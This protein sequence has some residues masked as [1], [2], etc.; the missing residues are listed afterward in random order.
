VRLPQA[1]HTG[2]PR[3]LLLAG[4]LSTTVLAVA[5]VGAGAIPR[6]RDAIASTL[7][8]NVLHDND[9]LQTICTVAMLIA[10]VVLVSCWWRLR[11]LLNGLT[12][13]ALL[14][15]AGVWSLPLLFAPPLF[16][17][18]V[19]AY[20]GQ[21]EL[22]A[23]HI[24]PY[25]YGPAALTGKWVLRVDDPWRSSPAP[26]GPVW[27]WLAGRVVLI[28]GEHV[29]LAVIA[30]RFVAVAGL[31]LVAATLPILARQHGVAPQRA[32]WLGLAN[33]FVLLHGVAG[34]HNDVLMVGLLVAG[35][36]VAGRSPT[37]LRLVLAAVLIT[38]AAL[39][40]LPAI[41]ALGF[42]PMLYPGWVARLRSAAVVL[43]TS[44]VTALGLTAATG[45]GWGWVHTL[46]AGATKLSIFSPVTGIGVAVGNAL[47]ALGLVS[48]PNAVIR[49]AAEGGLALAVLVGVGLLFRAHTV[50]P[51]RALALTMV[52]VVALGPIVQPWYLLWGLVLMAAVGG[53]RAMLP[54]GALSIALCLALLPNGRS[55]IRPPLYGT[56]VVVAAGFATY[57]VRRSGRQLTELPGRPVN[58][59]AA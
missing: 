40:K 35:L 43:G 6:G 57:L 2:V 42:L 27:L 15:V 33:P 22:V 59:A 34:A 13:R 29:Q 11:S 45:L 1:L 48:G 17:A 54:L 37:S 19:Y 47:E 14:I 46:N 21:G 32:L 30:L 5:G 39:V 28:V 16:S 10:M 25:T 52:A 49:I 26:Y 41:A 58:V 51:V 3:R 9:V 8:L 7:H 18:D 12:P 31:L 23:N 4:A 55:L 50:G 38:T 53:E 56:P 44:A 20:A 24:D 36:A